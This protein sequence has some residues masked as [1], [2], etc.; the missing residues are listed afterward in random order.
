MRFRPSSLLL[1][2][3]VT[4]LPAAAIAQ[5]PPQQQQQGPVIIPKKAPTA[6][7]PPPPP[8]Q[9]QQEQKPQFRFSVT[10]P[11]VQI[12]V[13][14]Q[15]KNNG[16]FVPNLTAKQFRIY[17]DG[18]EQQ[19]EKVGV[20]NDAPMT[21][22]ML[23]EFSNGTF[24]PI[25]Y[26]VLEASAVFTNQL[27]P[28][29]WMAL[30]TYDLKSTIV[31]DFTH[32]K[33]AIYAGLNSLQ[34]ANFSETDLFDALSDTIDRLND[35]QGHKVLVVM[36][37]GFNSFSHLTF[38]QLKKKLQATQDI[39]IYTVSLDWILEAN[40]IAPM[41]LLQADNEMKYFAEVTGGRSY[42]PRFEAEFPDDFRDIAGSVRSQYMISYT[43]TNRKL[44]GTERKIKVELVAPDGKP[45]EIVD[46]KGKKLKYDLSYR[47]SY[48]SRHVVE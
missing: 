44:D 16:Q 21:V 43:P 14:V 23:L 30:V 45:L 25:E 7:T 42:Q 24:Y 12:P 32:D 47:P 48:T 34:M 33:R 9:Q 29:D 26:Q 37:T 11:E 15:L 35:I 10:V 46:Q 31:T 4:A 20:T 36:G 8:P 38:D 5:G 6:P 2:L 22:V 41:R 3:L 17:E 19:I 13:T 1:L 18:V 28:Q 39:T 27:Q 40:S